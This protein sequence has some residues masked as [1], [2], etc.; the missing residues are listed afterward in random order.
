MEEQEKRI[1]DFQRGTQTAKQTVMQAQ[2]QVAEWEKRAKAA[3]SELENVRSHLSEAE[4]TC[5]G[6]ERA[7]GE[8]KQELEDKS[9]A[10]QE[11]VNVQLKLQTDLATL[12]S[13]LSGAQAE[14]A[15]A[16]RGRSRLPQVANGPTWRAG[17]HGRPLSR[18][19]QATSYAATP[20]RRKGVPSALQNV[21]PEKQTFHPP[22]GPASPQPPAV[23]ASMHAPANYEDTSPSEP[24]ETPRLGNISQTQH[25][26]PSMPSPTHSTISL[27]PTEQED[28]W[29]A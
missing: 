27:A 7:N 26:R 12:A 6:W 20:S 10:E 2:Q 17:S 19:S 16:A 4:E 29:W 22:S 8:L 15:E 14:L 23:W 25:Y 24:P 9:Q 1:T 21:N 3:E 28:G 18:L 5:A 13:K 11:S